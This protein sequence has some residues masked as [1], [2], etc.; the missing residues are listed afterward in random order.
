MIYGESEYIFLYIQVVI[1]DVI[2][3]E[4]MAI[5][6]DCTSCK[7]VDQ[8][9]AISHASSRPRDDRVEREQRAPLSLSGFL[10]S[11]LSCFRRVII[12]RVG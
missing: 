9:R 8:V 3:P 10:R 7:V 6:S 1:Y 5:L 2:E 12:C 4:V 11:S